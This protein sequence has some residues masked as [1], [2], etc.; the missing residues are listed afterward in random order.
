VKF[1]LGCGRRIAVG[2]TNIDFV[3]TLPGVIAHDLTRGIPAADGVAEVVYSSHVLEH[4]D[5]AKGLSFLRACHRVLRAGGTLR[6][7]VPDLENIAQAYLQTLREHDTGDPSA[8]WRRDWM[9]I[10]LY[11]QAMRAETGG[12]MLRAIRT[13]NA[14]QQ[15]F[16]RLR[17]GDEATQHFPDA[18][19][20][21]SADRDAVT[22]ASRPAT[23]RWAR[24]AKAA[25]SPSSWKM[26]M[27]RKLLGGD[28]VLLQQARFR[29]RGEIHLRMYDRL[30]LAAAMEQAGFVR[31]C[32]CDAWTSRV[33]GWAAHHLDANPDGSVYKPDSLYMEATRP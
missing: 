18:A 26:A 4:F 31:V 12:E 32:R 11:D 15:A 8:A 6:I 29:A 20:P 27:E 5:A 24:R 16:I 28:H 21:S 3:S 10:E 30:S 13:A 9:A 19:S 2:W 17:L 33:N 22:S 7:V 14:E 25:F 1:N 23:S